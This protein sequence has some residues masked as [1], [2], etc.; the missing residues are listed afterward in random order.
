MEREEIINVLNG[1]CERCLMKGIFST[2]MEAKT[3]CD[4]FDRFKNNNFKNDE[5]YSATIVY[6]HNLAV[7]LH[8]S[9]NTSLGESYSL[10]SAILA[11]DSIDFVESGEN[12][13]NDVIKI[14]PTKLKRSNRS[15]DN[16][17]ID[18]TDN[19]S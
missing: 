18:V 14:E 2:L 6:F 3:L 9:G 7:K 13:V 19:V 5:E 8:E 10:Y 17:V 15:K 16:D 12:I 1:M 11:A 4:T